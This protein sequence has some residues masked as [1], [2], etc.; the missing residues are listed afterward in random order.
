LQCGCIPDVFLSEVVFFFD[1]IVGLYTPA[2]PKG[3]L[4]LPRMSPAC[5]VVVVVVVTPAVAEICQ[6]GCVFM[7]LF[8][9]LG[10]KNTVNTCKVSRT[11]N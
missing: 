7:F 9:T 6:I 8:E 1:F 4:L 11:R 5:S 10:A 3:L 2:I